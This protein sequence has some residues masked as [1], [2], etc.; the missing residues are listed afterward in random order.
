MSSTHNL[1]IFWASRLIAGV[2]STSV[3]VV[4]TVA[5][6]T[7]AGGAS[8]LAPM[9]SAQAIGQ[10][11]ALATSG[12]IIDR[13]NQNTF[14][15]VVQTLTGRAWFAF[16]LLLLLD[17]EPRP[18]WIALGASLGPLASLN[19]PATQSL[20]SFLVDRD[21]MKT[22]IA[23]IR[24]SLNVVALLSPVLAGAAIALL[25]LAA[26]PLTMTLLMLGSALTRHSLQYPNGRTGGPTQSRTPGVVRHCPAGNIS[27]EPLLGRILPTPRTHRDRWPGRR[28]TGA[29]GYCLCVVRSRTYRRRFLLSPQN[30]VAYRL[31]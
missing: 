2:S 3:P 30:V 8:V 22:A 26:P 6:L 11:V 24:I 20:L 28:R 1:N 17:T 4:L 10:L 5:T 15:V 29:V 16:V 18:L 12:A 13:V 19:G 21:A 25:L 27:D 9:L 7:A 14:L 23:N 31:R